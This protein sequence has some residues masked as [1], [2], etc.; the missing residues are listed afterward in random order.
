MLGKLLKYEIKAMGRI[1]LPIYLV[2]IALSAVFALTMR[3]TIGKTAVGF[4]E[5]F[6]IV[7]L[8]LFV[9]AIITACVMMLILV[10]Q[11]FYKHL[12]G[13]EGYLMFSLPVSTGQLILSKLLTAVLWIV[14]GLIAGV[15]AGFAMVGILSSVPEFMKEVQNAWNSL[16]TQADLTRNLTL[17]VLV[18]L[19][20]V[21]ASLCKVYASIAIGHQFG[22]NRA[23]FAVFAYVAI[24]IAELIVA[25]VVSK[26]DA[27]L[28]FR[29]FSGMSSSGLDLKNS[30][31]AIGISA[32]QICIYSVITWLLLDRRLNLE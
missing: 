19:A 31:T 23:L 21:I 32:I 1:M 17:F 28:G 7:T 18:I 22:R 5:K 16:F 13:T 11:R 3:L 29:I 8:V 9:A 2:L 4:L 14:I 10:I 15:L 25:W 6:A 26:I 12:L 27:S 24:G 30:L 20:G